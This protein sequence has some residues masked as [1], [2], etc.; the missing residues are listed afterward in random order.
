MKQQESKNKP[1]TDCF[2]YR[3]NKYGFQD[4]RALNALYCKNGDKCRFYKPAK[5]NESED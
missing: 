4:C 5:S 3:G 1:K 2:A